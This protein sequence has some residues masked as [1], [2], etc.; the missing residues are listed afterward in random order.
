MHLSSVNEGIPEP[1]VNLESTSPPIFLPSQDSMNHASP[2]PILQPR[3]AFGGS[4]FAVKSQ[5]PLI[6]PSQTS[7]LF[8]KQH[9]LQSLTTELSSEKAGL[10]VVS[11]TSV[12][13]SMTCEASSSPPTKKRR[14]LPSLGPASA[15]Q[16]LFPDVEC[17][18]WFSTNPELFATLAE[19]RRRHYQF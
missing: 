5:S 11:P 14:W 2:L 12:C 4:P 17:S 9:V 7:I 19:S 8:R 18:E 13:A 3:L 15:D 10:G 1:Q 16:P 6:P